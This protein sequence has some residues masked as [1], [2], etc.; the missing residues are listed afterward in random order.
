MG[1]GKI[2]QGKESECVDT[3]RPG[4]TEVE[5]FREEQVTLMAIWG[6]IWNP[7]MYIYEKHKKWSQQ[8]TVGDNPPIRH[9]ELSTETSRDRNELYL[10]KL[11]AKR[12]SLKPP[13]LSGYCQ[14]HW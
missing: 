4:Q 3:E 8:I 14:G 11:L 5:E 6:A 1:E 12:S 9:L 13:N 7:L 2:T 10:F